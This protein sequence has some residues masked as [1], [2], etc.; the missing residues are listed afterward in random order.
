MSSDPNVFGGV[1]GQAPSIPEELVFVPKRE[2]VRAR[3]INQEDSPLNGTVFGPGSII[4]LAIP[5][6]RRGYVDTRSLSIKFDFVI[7]TVAE[8]NL[9]VVFNDSG[10]SVI[11]SFA[12]YIGS[13]PVDNIGGYG[14]LA[15]TLLNMAISP[16]HKAGLSS[17]I[18]CATTGTTAG[19]QLAG[20]AAGTYRRTVVLPLL[21]AFTTMKMLQMSAVG[22]DIRFDITLANTIDAISKHITNRAITANNVDVGYTL[23]NVTLQY[24]LIELDASGDAVVASLRDPSIP[25]TLCGRTWK[26]SS[27]IIPLGT[28]GNQ[29]Y[30]QTVKMSSMTS[31][32]A[33]FRFN[34]GV[35]NNTR[36]STNPNLASYQFFVGQQVLPSR[37]VYLDA[38]N[39]AGAY[40]HALKECLS[41]RRMWATSYAGSCINTGFNT[42]QGAAV[43]TTGVTTGDF[44]STFV[45]GVET[46]AF[47]QSGDDLLSGTSTNNFGLRLQFAAATDVLCVLDYFAEHDVIVKLVAPGQAVV[48]M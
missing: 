23:Q 40:A 6:S 32:L 42:H 5:S 22:A 33:R 38:A 2:A 20:V 44:A 12:S 15:N 47:P 43:P 30:P 45:L 31:I 10:F 48:F 7:T 3:L 19:I 36:A 11:D 13:Y 37:P 9:S 1:S 8:A 25:L 46:E 14:D 4:Q 27:A 35:H 21:S 39:A 24:N 16:S 41:S 26:R 18:Q 17:T 28:N 29:D 34:T